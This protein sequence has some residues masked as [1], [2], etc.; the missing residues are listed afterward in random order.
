MKIKDIYKVRELS[1]LENGF[2]CE[3]QW[4]PDHPIYSGHFPDQPIT[5]GV[6]L[7]DVCLKLIASHLS[8]EVHLTQAKSLK[9]MS[10]VLP[11]SRILLTIENK[12]EQQWLCVGKMDDKAVFKFNL[13][14]SAN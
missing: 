14:I 7:M 1:K 11:Q 5:P 6:V 4:N 2:E 10:A 3:L 13:E 9:F 12:K 8:K